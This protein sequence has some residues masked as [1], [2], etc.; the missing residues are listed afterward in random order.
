MLEYENR[1]IFLQKVTFQ[2]DLISFVIEKVKNAMPWT[3]Y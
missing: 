2:L 3:H 1:K